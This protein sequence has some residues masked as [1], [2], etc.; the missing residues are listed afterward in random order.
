M[1][2]LLYA[3]SGGRLRDKEKRHEKMEKFLEEDFLKADF[4]CFLCG[5]KFKRLF[6]SKEEICSEEEFSKWSKENPRGRQILRK[7][8]KEDLSEED[9]KHFRWLKKLLYPT[10]CD[11]F[12]NQFENNV[13]TMLR[14]FIK[15]TIIIEEMVN[16]EL[17]KLYEEYCIE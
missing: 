6:D 8:M 7:I 5:V 2:Y 13:N 15:N 14:A 11:D 12:R 3:Y 4:N 17:A 16:E 1:Y 9:R 10:E